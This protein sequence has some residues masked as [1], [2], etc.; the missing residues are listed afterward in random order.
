MIRLILMLILVWTSTTNAK[1]IK[2]EKRGIADEHITC[3]WDN[4][5]GVPCVVI[6]PRYKNNSNALGDK[7]TPTITIKKSDIEKYN[8]IDL[9]KALNHIQGLDVTQ[10][11]PTGQQSSVFLRG[12]NSNHTFIECGL[13]GWSPDGENQYRA[14]YIR[15]QVLGSYAIANGQNMGSPINTNEWH[16]FVYTIKPRDDGTGRWDCGFHRSLEGGTAYDV[17]PALAQGVDWSMGGGIDYNRPWVAR[18]CQNRNL[19]HFTGHMDRLTV[20]NNVF[21]FNTVIKPMMEDPSSKALP[22]AMTDEKVWWD[23]NDGDVMRNL[24]FVTDTF[25][26]S[27]G[28]ENLTMTRNLNSE[29][30]WSETSFIEEAF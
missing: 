24:S 30:A 2:V 18:G 9:P 29:S 21:D 12:T 14:Q 7:V 10:S 28:G 15:T 13:R 5:D 22:A 6:L 8:L 3:E 27:G 19:N 23:F 17:T 26:G 16:Y 25:E 20:H 1:I 4:Q 11:G